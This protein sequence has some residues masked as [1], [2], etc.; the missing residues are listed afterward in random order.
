MDN[1]LMQNKLVESELIEEAKR[2]QREYHNEWSRK[3]RDKVN[4]TVRRYWM[5]KA[6]KLK[7]QQQEDMKHVNRS[8]ASC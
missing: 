6:L 3:N 5:K 8:Q 7:E 2:L 1:E 4:A